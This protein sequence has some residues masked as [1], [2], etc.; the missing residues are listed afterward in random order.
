MEVFS[1]LSVSKSGKGTDVLRLSCITLLTVLLTATL[2]IA[3]ENPPADLVIQDGLIRTLIPSRPIVEA[4]AVRDGFIVATGDKAQIQKLIGAKTRVISLAGATAVPGFEDAHM[5]LAGVGEELLTLN[6]KGIE[7]L[8][9][10]LE[11]IARRAKELPPG[12]WLTGRGWIET[13]WEPPRFP[14]RD[15]LDRVAPDHPVFLTRVDGHG[16]AL[17]LGF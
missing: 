17:G 6:L 2:V 15:D 16:G 7:S 14:T 11:A 12:T 8:E 10:F 3:K 1:A 9:A 5:H 4:L 13:F